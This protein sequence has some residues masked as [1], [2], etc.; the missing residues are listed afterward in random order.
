MKVVI[1]Q[2]IEALKASGLMTS[3]EIQ[4]FIEGLP[5]EKKPSDGAALARELV[6][7]KKLTRFQAQAV[8]QGKTKGLILG[9]Y[10]VLDRIGEGGM[11]Q[12]YR[13]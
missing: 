13:T 4:A 1:N 5:P 10:L 2:F 8:Y 7:Q 11:G 9:D 3:A 12:V 6:R